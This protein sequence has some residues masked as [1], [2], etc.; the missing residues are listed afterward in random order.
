MPDKDQFSDAETEKR[1][2][3]ALKRMLNTPPKLHK[4]SKLGKKK[5]KP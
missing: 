2:N 4:D 1:A 3:D 5:Q